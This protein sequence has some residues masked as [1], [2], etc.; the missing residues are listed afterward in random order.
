[1]GGA[2]GC[3][4]L[5]AVQNGFFT[6]E[7]CGTPSKEIAERSNTSCIQDETYPLSSIVRYR[8][9]RYYELQGPEFRRCEDDGEWTRPTPFCKPVCGKKESQ[10]QLSAGGNASEIGEWPWQAAIYDIKK[11]DVVCGGALIREEW[12]LTAAH[13]VVVE[14]S[15]RTRKSEEILVHLGKYYRSFIKKDEHVSKIILHR[16]F[17]VHNNYDSDI[18]LLKLGR[19]AVLTARVQLVCLP[20]RFDFSEANLDSG[21]PGWVA[22]WG[23]D[24]SDEL[25][26]VLTEVQLP[27]VSNRKC[28]LD[29]RNFTGDPDITRTLTSNM[30]CAGFAGDTPIEGMVS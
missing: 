24:G 6:F 12:V 3:G 29:T 28:V 10:I 30:F 4:Q 11:G 14:G 1:M 17:N 22:G 9:E 25:A 23:Y 15:L 20:N 2:I 16:D 26:A 18:A 13:C 19:P 21:V 27:V 5:T 8:C 7:S